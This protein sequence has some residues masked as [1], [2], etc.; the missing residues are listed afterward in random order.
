MSTTTTSTTTSASATSSC[1][2]KLYDIPVH[3]AACAMPMK[4]N[5]SS[6]MSSCCFSAS[7]VQYDDCD[8]YCLAEGQS[9]GTL[10]ECLI[11]ASEPGEVWCNTNANATATATATA[12]GT[13]IV[14]L[15]TTA[16]GSDPTGTATSSGVTSTSTATSAGI[17]APRPLSKSAIGAVGLL[18]VGSAAGLFI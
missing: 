18:L 9:V 15:S 10:A 12:T 3:D 14:T 4:S 2:A 7:V 6:I 5:Y 1:Y 8:Y 13:D 16:T 11:K 17:I